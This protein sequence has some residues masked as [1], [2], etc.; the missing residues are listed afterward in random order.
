MGEGTGTGTGARRA[1]TAKRKESCLAALKA[2]GGIV[3]TALEKAGVPRRTFYNWREADADFS[4][5]VD[6]IKEYQV[7]YVESK[8]MRL[9]NDGDTTATIFYLKCMGKARGWSDRAPQVQAAPAPAEPKRDERQHPTLTKRL[10]SKKDYIVRLLK[11]QGKYT[12]ELSMQVSV[13]AQLLVRT[14]ELAGD[15]FD[16]AHEAVRTEI[17]RE[18]NTREVVSPKERLYLDYL[19]QSQRALRAL[20]MNTDA[21]ERRPEEDGFD[22]F[23]KSMSDD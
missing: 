18:G 21:K 5:A 4:A 14:D 17:S 22:D 23:L 3:G 2:S 13:V 20:G 7:D 9:I 1:D 8:L 12:A 10:K 11:K 6:D 16:G 19:A 15:I